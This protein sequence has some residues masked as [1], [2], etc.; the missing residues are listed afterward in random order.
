MEGIVRALAWPRPAKG[1]STGKR[2]CVM[3][4]FDSHQDQLRT[5]DSRRYPYVL[6]ISDLLV[7]GIRSNAQE[8]LITR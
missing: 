1:Q 2:I 6:F 5:Q 8:P 7:A 3:R 4:S